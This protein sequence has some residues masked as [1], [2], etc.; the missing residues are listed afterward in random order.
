MQNRELKAAGYH[1]DLSSVLCY[2]LEEGMGVGRA[3]QDSCCCAEEI[4]I[5]LLSNYSLI[6]SVKK[7][8]NGTVP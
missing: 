7:K 5:M 8:K 1:R 4:N 2:D 6:K 3:A